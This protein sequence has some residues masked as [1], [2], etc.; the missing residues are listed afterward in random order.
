MRKIADPKI[1]ALGMTYKPDSDDLRESPALRIIEILKGE[2]YDIKSYDNFVKGFE[3]GSIKDIAVNVDCIVTLVEHT[4][5]R[6]EL[7]RDGDEIRLVMRN[8][9]ILG[10]GTS[11]ELDAYD[12]RQ[13]KQGDIRATSLKVKR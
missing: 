12:L 7:E 11:Y 6:E 8:P 1:V 4:A 10:L 9:T 13:R 2:G 3:Y 5:I